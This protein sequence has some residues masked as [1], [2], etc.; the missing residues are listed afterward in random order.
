MVPVAALE[1]ALE[2]LKS[3]FASLSLEVYPLSGPGYWQVAEAGADGLTLYQ[4]TYDR[5]TY[6]RVH[7]AG[8]KRDYDWRLEAPERAGEAGL[9]RLGIGALLGLYDWR[10]EAIALALHAD[11]LMKRFWRAQVSIS[12]PRPPPYPGRIYSR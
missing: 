4:E 9:R 6:S 2:L 11:Y 3:D 8:R 10:S 1:K 7:P 5:E 12:F